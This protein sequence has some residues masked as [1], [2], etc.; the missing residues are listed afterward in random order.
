MSDYAY[1]LDECVLS[2]PPGFRDASVHALE[3][4]L[5]DGEQLSLLVQ[6]E[7]RGDGALSDF[8]RGQTQT[9]PK[10]FS[11]YAEEEPVAIDGDVPM[12]SKRFRWRHETGVL[13]HHQVFVELDAVILMVTASG[14]ASHMTAVDDLVREVAL[15]L[16]PREAS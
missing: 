13:Y 12:V 10:R 9:Y 16:Q 6:R 8:V 2:L 4:A 11:A 14:K 15:G 1:H 5:D 7:P 3:W